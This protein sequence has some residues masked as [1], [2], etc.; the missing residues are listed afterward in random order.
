MRVVAPEAGGAASAVA[1]ELE[2][3]SVK[4][5]REVQEVFMVTPLPVD[6]GPSL[7]PLCLEQWL[8]HLSEGKGAS[9]ALKNLLGAEYAETTD[10]SE[11]DS[12]RPVSTSVS[13]EPSKSSMERR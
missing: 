10:R 6:S 9:K 8:P 7:E 11:A 12:R 3:P 5:G 1:K 2:G 4:R 13:W